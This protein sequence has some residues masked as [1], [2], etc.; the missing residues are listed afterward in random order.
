M[1]GTA[2]ARYRS[3]RLNPE[4]L[5][6]AR[7]ALLELEEVQAR[8]T[9]GTLRPGDASNVAVGV[10]RRLA[11]GL[12][13]RTGSGKH[14]APAGLSGVIAVAGNGWVGESARQLKALFPQLQED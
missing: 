2:Q 7:E 5:D 3:M 6:M 4:Q 11:R 10:L 12:T 13:H 9:N 14:V 1:R 8:K